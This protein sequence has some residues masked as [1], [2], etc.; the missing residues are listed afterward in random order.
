MAEAAARNA[1]LDLAEHDALAE[2]LL[3][4][5]DDEFVI[6][7]WDSEW[8]GIAPMLEEDVAT[9]SIAQDEIGHAKALYEL[10]AELTDDDAD[11][12]AY[13]RAAE[14]FRHAAL[15]NHARGDWAFSVA[16][17]YLYETA[18]AVRLSTLAASSYEPLALLA[19]KMRR[20]ETYHLLHADAWLR[21]L[22]DGPADARKRLASAVGALWADAQE[23]FAPLDGEAALLAARLLAEPMAAMHADWQSQVRRTLEPVAGPL[24]SSTPS[25]DGRRRRTDAFAWLH[26][27]LTSVASSEPAA[28]W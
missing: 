8:T 17:R 24:P 3:G 7:F 28:T 6:G 26:R 12:I 23:V 4:I 2:L 15:L 16:R 14:D 11:R 10:L 20:E 13:G 5:A 22:A 27:E 1:P 25:P 19:G 9:S 18:D 21:R